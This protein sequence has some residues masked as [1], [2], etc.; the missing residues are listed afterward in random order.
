MAYSPR[1]GLVYLPTVEM[2]GVLFDTSDGAT[3]KPTLLNGDVGLLPAEVLP[4][5]QGQLPPAVEALT[6]KPEDLKARSFLQAWDPILNRS[7]WRSP[8]RPYWDHGG[9]MASAGDLVFQGD[10]S[11]ILRAFDAK[12]GAI[13]H[14]IDTGSSIMAAPM[15]YQVG[16]TAYVVVM[17]GW[18]GGAWA[19]PHP[20][21]AAYQYGN[22]GRILAFRLG[23]GKVPHP[24]A[25]PPPEPIPPPPPRTGTPQTVAR[26]GQI[27]NQYCSICHPNMPRT[28]SADLR[29]LPAGIHDAF[30]RIVRDGLLKDAG[31]PGWG[32]VLSDT[33][34]NAI[35]D[36]VI[37]I[38]WAAYQAQ[39]HGGSPST[40]VAPKHF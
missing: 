30:V 36:Y 1:T 12:S 19:I 10:A 2:G 27:F 37:D 13:L 15:E 28:G 20:E 9:A 24:P 39:Q 3:Y 4:L 8:D 32:D 35:H 17:A 40:V 26:G 22:A 23:G 21:S 38:S 18:G 5:L 29:A 33:D 7:V 16:G 31:M 34:I 14:E 11:G 25:L 6:P